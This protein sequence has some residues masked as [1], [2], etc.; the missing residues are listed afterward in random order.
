ML[1][2]QP[3]RPLGITGEAKRPLRVLG[4]L[5]FRQSLR[6]VSQRHT[7]QHTRVIAVFLALLQFLGQV[8]NRLLLRIVHARLEC[9]QPFGFG[10]QPALRQLCVRCHDQCDAVGVVE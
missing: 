3:V 5:E 4:A 1:V 9:C 8:D 7:R 2:N 10:F 6:H